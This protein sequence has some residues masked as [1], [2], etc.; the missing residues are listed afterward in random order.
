MESSEIKIT[1]AIKRDIPVILGL[2][3]ELDRPKPKNNEELKTFENY[4]KKY[5]A[6]SD[7]KLLIAKSKSTVVGMVSM[8]FLV[9]LNQVKNELYIP[10]LVVTKEYQKKG[11]GKELINSCINI[12]KEQNCYRIRLESG[13]Q[14]EESHKFYKKLGFKQSSLSFTIKI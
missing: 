6:D 2:L 4:L 1:E 11:I 12:G 3:Y 14:R 9:R 13:N 8:M 5:I 7:K 10:E